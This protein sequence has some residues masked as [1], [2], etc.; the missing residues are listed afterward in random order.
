MDVSIVELQPGF[1]QAVAQIDVQHFD[2]LMTAVNIDADTY[3][4]FITGHK[5]NKP[6]K[7]PPEP[8]GI[9]L[10]KIQTFII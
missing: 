6:T 7:A 1:T 5:A 2:L 4:M 8:P 3:P 10:A 9:L